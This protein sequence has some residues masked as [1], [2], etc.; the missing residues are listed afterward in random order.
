MTSEEKELADARAEFVAQWG[1]IGTNWGINRT[2]AQIHALLLVSP[3]PQST[4]QVMEELGISRGN[5]NMN[6]RELVSWGLAR[7]VVRKGE[8]KE[9]FEAEKDVWEMA[10][11]IARERRRREIEPAKAVLR[12]CADRTG[13]FGSEEG[14]EF[15][16][17]INELLE[18]VEFGS[19]L[20]DK[21]VSSGQSGV[22]KLAA[23]LLR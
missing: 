11:I 5:A 1:A 23:K 13:K 6:L 7:G 21:A 15:H 3:D 18:F 4:D 19:G 8:R 17:Q 22:L 12:D 16:R 9:Y 2:F 14:K 20:F 10:V